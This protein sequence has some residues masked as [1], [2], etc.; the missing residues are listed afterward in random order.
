MPSIIRSSGTNAPHR[1]ADSPSTAGLALARSLLTRDRGF[2]DAGRRGRLR[3]LHGSL[4][5][6]FDDVRRIELSA[7]QH[8]MWRGNQ[9]PFLEPH[10]AESDADFNR[11]IHL[12]TLNLTRVVID[13]L[14][15]LYR[16]PTERTLEGGSQAW[17]E[18]ISH[19][20][21]A[22]PLDAVL[23]AADRIARLQGVAGVQPVWVDGGLSWRVW[24]AHRLAVVAD[25]RTPWKALAVVTLSAGPA[26]DALG[27]HAPAAFADVWTDEEWIRVEGG[28][29]TARKQ[30]GYGRLP[31]AFFRDQWPVDSFWVE[32]RGR[33]LCFD[34]AVL[35]GRLSDLAEVVAL[36]GF[37]LMEIINPDPHQDILLGPGRA[38]AFRP[39][40][41]ERIGINFKQPNAPIGEL[42]DDIRESIR[43]ILLSQR[44][45][46][47]A[48]S[49]SVSGSTSGIAIFAANTPVAEDRQERARLFA[50]AEAELHAAGIA[51]A[52]Q[53]GGLELRDAPGMRVS[54][55]GPELLQIGAES[56]R[57][58]EWL[59]ANG[60]IAPWQIM[61]RDNPDGFASPQEAKEKW[62]AQ[63]AE[64]RRLGI[65]ETTTASEGI[66]NE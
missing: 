34:N 30:H 20:W 61:Y 18:L 29:V 55:P 66:L 62:I 17:H 19:A 57:R 39:L 47:H 50:G 8:E 7:F 51:V 22:A 54:Y 41:D 15:G 38:V 6:G 16:S 53:H 10:P 26:Y 44:V 23:S 43:Q 65:G 36:Q 28:E 37:G 24:P 45:P 13:V 21:Q 46:E 35:N 4:D 48:L 11:R 3:R 14:S 56:Q 42:L 59:L 12:R 33:T 49:V 52:A 63:R 27:R 2:A 9:L 31:F 40:G 64:L 1:E 60:L 5:G 58:D 32:G 25:P